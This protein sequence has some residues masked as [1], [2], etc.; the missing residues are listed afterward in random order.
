MVG[1]YS[2]ISELSGPFER[3]ISNIVKNGNC[4]GKVIFDGLV[5]GNFLT[6]HWKFQQVCT[7]PVPAGNFVQELSLENPGICCSRDQYFGSRPNK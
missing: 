2:F 5:Q 1:S 3:M 6:S 7:L 4:E